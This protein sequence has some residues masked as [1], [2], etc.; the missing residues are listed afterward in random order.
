ASTA[1]GFFGEFIDTKTLPATGTYTIRVDPSGMNTGSMTLTLYDVPPDV[2]GTITPGGPAVTV[3]AI[4]PGQNAQLTF[5]GTAAQRVSLELTNVTTTLAFVSLLNP[6]GSTL[7]FFSSG[8]FGAFLDA[9]TLPASGTYTLR[10]D[11]Y[12][13]YTGSVTLRLYNVVDVTGTV[14]IGGPA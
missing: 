5:S 14:T 12:G 10:V 4:T 11:P 9:T 2:T 8:M 7:A 1:V 6:D 13:T 3:T